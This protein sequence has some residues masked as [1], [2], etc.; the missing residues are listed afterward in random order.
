MVYMKIE[1]FVAI[2][3]LSQ[4]VFGYQLKEIQ[5]FNTPLPKEKQQTFQK[6][7]IVICKKRLRRVEVMQRAI[8]FYKS[9]S[10]YSFSS[11]KRSK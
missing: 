9:S 11:K 3:L 6:D 10:T 2:F 4:T 7:C 5:K 8:D 1:I